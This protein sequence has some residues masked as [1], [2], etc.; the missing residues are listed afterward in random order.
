MCAVE[1]I[2]LI[3]LAVALAMDAFAVAVAVGIR[4]KTVNPRQMFR[5][6]WHFGLFQAM[7]PV[8]GWSL[9][10]NVRSF[11][12]SFDHWIAFGLLAFVGGKMIW[13][14]FHED[15]E[16]EGAQDPTRSVSLV[17]LSIATSIDALA[18]GFSMSVL[19]VAIAF[20]AVVIGITASTFTLL[21]MQLGS[22]FASSSRLGHW[23]EIFGGVVL[24]LIGFHI[25]YEH[26]C[27]G[28]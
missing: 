24:F 2:P 26:G 12:E 18:V 16:A 6:S 3:S 4:L 23:A 7:M 13:E 22:R 8:L 10:V 5:L 1:L 14:A 21:G 25:L 9:G 15:E 19:D 20:P 11:V 28:G 17:V 27:L